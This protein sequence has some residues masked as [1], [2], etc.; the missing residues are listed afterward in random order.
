MASTL[1]K[2]LDLEGTCLYSD[3]LVYKNKES[4]CLARFSYNSR[5]KL[6]SDHTLSFTTAWKQKI[7]TIQ[8]LCGSLATEGTNAIY[9]DWTP[10]L[11]KEYL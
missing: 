1:T 3:F 9:F 11:L 4:C 5:L 7:E 2:L 6:L 8:D 10:V